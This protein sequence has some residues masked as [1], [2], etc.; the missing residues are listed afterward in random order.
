MATVGPV[1][2][3]HPSPTFRRPS[4]ITRAAPSS[5]QLP[6]PYYGH[7][8]T[9]KT[10]AHFVTHLFACPD[11]PPPSTANP[12]TPSP[13]LAIFIA[14]ALHRTRLHASVTFAALYLLQ[15][16]KARFPAARG[17]S[18]HRLFI[19]AFMLASKVICDDT[20]SNKSWS[21]VGQGMFALREI[22]QMEREMCSY[23]E[24]Q[25]NVDPPQLR[26]FEAKVRRDFKGLGPYPN[27]VLP[28]PAPTPMP[29]TTPYGAA[30]SSSHPPSFVSGRVSSTSP[31]K[32]TAPLRVKTSSPEEYSDPM[33]PDMPD[34][35]E[36]YRSTS[37]SPASSASPP[38]PPG[39]EDLSAKIVVHE[40]HLPMSSEPMI[41]PPTIVSQKA[42]PYPASHSLPAPPQPRHHHRDQ[43]SAPLKKSKGD[44][45]FAVA[46]P[47]Y[48]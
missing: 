7:E 42:A 20:Y 10:C 40:G 2:A 27:Y 3:R 46:M 29:S 9:A 45:A 15:R 8:E 36:S 38:T 47:C 39:M 43:P 24:W 11:L 25:L 41:P 33:S 6:D 12:P 13:T 32:P 44:E 26:E 30:A 17:S 18:G 35:P 31:P 5:S 19:S 14:Y 21:I 48:W 16:L 22:N 28:S 37:T 23:L 34:T 1:L 4:R